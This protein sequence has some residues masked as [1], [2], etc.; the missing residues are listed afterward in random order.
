MS[1]ATVAE[2][3]G[4][5]EN[6]GQAYVRRGDYDWMASLVP[7]KRVLEIG[8]GVGFA[9]Q[10]LAR[11][12]LT[13][14]SIDS[15]ADC[16]A[17][18]RQRIESANVRLMQADLSA[19]TEDQRTAIEAFSPDSVVC[20][21]MGAPAE[22]TGAATNDAGRAVIA[23]REK[24]H[25][26][27]A[28]LAA[29]LPT[30]KT[31]HIIDRTAIPWQA[32]DIGRDTLVNYHG[33]KTLL[34]LPFVAVRANALYRKLGDDTVSNA[35]IRNTHPSLKGVVPTLASLLVERKQ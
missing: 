29:S 2:F 35:Q 33:G 14:L 12:G 19:L 25:R 28:E 30:V 23:Y 15:L 1:G 24:I 5:W 8:C 18:T 11:R 34:D 32:K 31:L 7:G 13:V 4:Y 27:V 21:L 9:T 10:A 22:T 16:L 6:E 3:I 20:W 26:L 17:L